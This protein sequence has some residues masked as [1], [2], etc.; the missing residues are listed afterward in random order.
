MQ[1]ATLVTAMILQN[2]DLRLDDP[3]YNLQ[4]KQALTLKP[5]DLYIRAS[6]R[7][8][9]GATLLDHQ[10][11]ATKTSLNGPMLN[12]GSR[13]DAG[14]VKP[15]AIY[16]GSNSG[17]CQAFAQRLAADASTKGFKAVVGD[18]DSAVDKLPPDVPV[19]LITSSYEGQ[20]PDNA[21]QFIE[22]LQCQ[23]PESMKDINFAVF[24]CGHSAFFS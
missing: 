24:G 17:T 22:W 10:L 3:S 1:E 12:G 18:L 14:T 23:K 5:K 20:P 2:F 16:F 15:M 8:G 21:A 4:R 11:H 9:M 19:I 6:L 13:H 7:K